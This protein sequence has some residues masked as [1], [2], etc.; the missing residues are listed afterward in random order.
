[1][2]DDERTTQDAG[3]AQWIEESKTALRKGQT[4]RF[5]LLS[6]LRARGLSDADAQKLVDELA[7]QVFGEL[8][9]SRPRATDAWKPGVVERSGMTEQVAEKQRA[10]LASYHSPWLFS[11]VG[12]ALLALLIVADVAT[13]VFQQRQRNLLHRLETQALQQQQPRMIVPSDFRPVTQAELDEHD[14][15]AAVLG[16]A[17]LAFY[18]SACIAFFIWMKRCYNNLRAFGGRELSYSSLQVWLSV[19]LPFI[20]LV[21]PYRVVKEVWQVSTTTIDPGNKWQ[22][23]SVTVPTSI[24]LWWTAFILTLVANRVWIINQSDLG[25]TLGENTYGQL[26]MATHLV[27]A[28]LTLVVM[29]QVTQ[30][31]LNKYAALQQAHVTPEL[32]EALT[33]LQEGI[34]SDPGVEMAT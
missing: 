20:N 33:L 21:R 28:A 30:R 12:I 34:A 4:S 24:H 7:E 22:W 3:L 19:V 14:A 10:D 11:I 23:K 32:S 2:T 6:D 16:L 8:A 27:G 9:S 25:M 26:F 15:Q 5:R 17:W 18:A 29:W 1:M 13:L 31:Q